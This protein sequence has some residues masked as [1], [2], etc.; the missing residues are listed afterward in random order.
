MRAVAV[1]WLTAASGRRAAPWLRRNRLVLHADYYT[2][3]IDANSGVIAIGLVLG[4]DYTRSELPGTD[5]VR[6]I[7]IDRDNSG[8]GYAS[9]RQAQR[10]LKGTIVVAL[11]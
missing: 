3:T 1:W 4:E 6:R 7:I 10:K 11:I 2:A 5:S 9:I 8:I